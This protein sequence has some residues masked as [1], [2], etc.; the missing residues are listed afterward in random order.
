MRN[1]EQIKIIYQKLLAQE[2]GDEKEIKAAQEKSGKL[3]KTILLLER[4]MTEDGLKK[5]KA[6]VLETIRILDSRFVVYEGCSEELQRREYMKQNGYAK[7]KKSLVE[8][9]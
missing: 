2:R 5:Q 4:G 7:L 1:L 3:R 6:D 8:I 9:N